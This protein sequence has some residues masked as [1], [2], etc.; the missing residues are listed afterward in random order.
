MALSKK[1]TI[2]VVQGALIQV[3]FPNVD[4]KQKIKMSTPN[5]MVSYT[6]QKSDLPKTWDY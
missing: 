3:S 5:T 6:I 4:S 1:T 2:T